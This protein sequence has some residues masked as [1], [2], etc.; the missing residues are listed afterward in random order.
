VVPLTFTAPRATTLSSATLVGDGADGFSIRYDGCAGRALAAGEPC[1]VLVRHLASRPGLARATVQILDAGGVTHTTTLEGFAWGGITR[2][3]LVSPDGDWVGQGRTYLHTP[4][5]ARIAASADPAEI[6]MQMRSHHDVWSLISAPAVGD[7][8]TAPRTYTDAAWWRDASPGP[9]LGVFG[10]GR[11]CDYLQNSSFTVDELRQFA[12]GDTRSAV[13]R[14]EQRCNGGPALRGTWSFRGGDQTKAPP[15]VLVDGDNATGPP[16]DENFP[17]VDETGPPLDD[18]PPA[19]PMSSPSASAALATDLPATLAT[20]TNSIPGGVQSG[21]TCSTR[22]AITIRLRT[23]PTRTAHVRVNGRLVQRIKPRTRRVRV[24][25]SD[26][27]VGLRD[28][29][30]HAGQ[31]T[32]R[33]ARVSP[34]RG[35][36][37]KG[38]VTIMAPARSSYGLGHGFRVR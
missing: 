20:P 18:R 3:E 33:P 27:D 4:A 10:N 13:V 26:H 35:G 22:R 28:R 23:F 32:A 6:F 31:K 16:T 8:L 9:L 2:I 38:G 1:R 5:T 34:V 12:S 11:A 14:F 19:G 15:W 21:T 17:P 36:S 30:R 7:S 29:P 25:F 37:P 24:R